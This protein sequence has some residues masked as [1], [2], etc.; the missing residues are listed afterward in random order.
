MLPYI[1]PA[2]SPLSTENGVERTPS[3]H[4]EISAA[5]NS[6][7]MK[8]LTMA[9]AQTICYLIPFPAPDVPGAPYFN[10]SD[11]TRF[12]D[13][14]KLLGKNHGVEDTVLVRKLP[15]YCEPVIQDEVK[16]QE[17]Y[18]MND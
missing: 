13:R 4:S 18:I 17:G 6:N 2:Q 1:N 8:S 9:A 10:G 14:F 15:E 3:T 7:Q 12:L 5:E 11:V 16:V